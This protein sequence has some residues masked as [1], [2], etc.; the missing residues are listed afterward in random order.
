STP[1]AAGAAGPP[2]AAG[3]AGPVPAGA[4]TALLEPWLP[5]QRWFAHKGTDVTVTGVGLVPLAAAPSSPPEGPA[6]EEDVHVLLAV[7]STR[8]GDGEEATYQVPLTV[9]P[10]PVP[11]LEHAVVGE[12]AGLG[13][14]HDGPHDPA[15]VRALLHLVS[16]GGGAGTLGVP[17]LHGV[18]PA[19]A[20]PVPAG[21]RSRI[22]RGEQSNTS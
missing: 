2:S 6:G 19:G 15:F 3:A 7:V 13:R 16:T 5:R 12:L 18:A 20:L 14:V 11:E 22:T 8:T 4:L 9:R 1:P 10:S 21:T 17:S